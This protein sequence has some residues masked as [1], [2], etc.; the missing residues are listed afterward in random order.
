[1]L[2]YAPGTAPDPY[3]SGTVGQRGTFTRSTAIVDGRFRPVT[4]D[5]DGDGADEV[6]WH[7][8]ATAPDVRWDGVPSRHTSTSLV[9]G[10]DHLPV[11]GDFDGDGRDDI[12]WYG[13]AG[14]GDALWWSEPDGAATSRPLVAT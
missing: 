13:P 9:V 2:W 7:G 3:W 12:A 14:A 6:V 10:G 5:L 8:P 1:V 11:T 4:G